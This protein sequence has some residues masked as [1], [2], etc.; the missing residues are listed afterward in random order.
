[1]NNKLRIHIPKT[2]NSFKPSP[3]FKRGVSNS[4]F[5]KLINSDSFQNS[6]SMSRILDD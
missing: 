6:H 3:E 4:Y 5:D 1:M 2:K